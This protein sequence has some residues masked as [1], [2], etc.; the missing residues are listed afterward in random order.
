MRL[1][2]N[3]IELAHCSDTRIVYPDIDPPFAVFGRTSRQFLDCSS[4]GHVGG[5]CQCA[6]PVRLADSSELF[7]RG[8]APRSQGQMGT[9]CGESARSGTTDATGSPGDYDV[10]ELKSLTVSLHATREA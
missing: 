6:Y 2:R 5:Q 4:I 3:R 9:R 10:C 8:S 7:K 1:D